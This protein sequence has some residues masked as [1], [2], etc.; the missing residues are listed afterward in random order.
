MEERRRLAGLADRVGLYYLT[1]R[2]EMGEGKRGSAPGH[3]V[4]PLCCLWCITPSPRGVHLESPFPEQAGQNRPLKD[5]G[6][7][8]L[9]AKEGICPCLSVC[10]PACLLFCMLHRCESA[11]VRKLIH[12]PHLALEK[13]PLS[14]PW[15]LEL[16]FNLTVL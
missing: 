9:S 14:L 13:G 1:V 11:Q 7:G 2:G 15:G 5:G 12:L 3:K 6:C 10:L 4:L 16:N 8:C